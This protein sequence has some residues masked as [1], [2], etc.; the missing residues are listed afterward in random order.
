M[1]GVAGTVPGWVWGITTAAFGTFPLKML[2]SDNGR[3]FPDSTVPYQKPNPGL[4]QHLALALY[5]LA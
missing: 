4:T 5:T 2:A 3:L 1:K